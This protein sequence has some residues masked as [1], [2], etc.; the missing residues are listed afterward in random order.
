MNKFFQLWNLMR[1]SALRDIPITIGIE[2]I[3][4]TI[5]LSEHIEQ[6]FNQSCLEMNWRYSC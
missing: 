3:D 5:S 2:D 6:F 4:E 1:L